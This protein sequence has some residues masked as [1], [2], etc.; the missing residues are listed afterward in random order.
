MRFKQFGKYLVDN[1]YADGYDVYSKDSNWLVSKK[2]VN[3]INETTLDEILSNHKKISPVKFNIGRLYFLSLH[4]KFS[5]NEI[6][7]WLLHNKMY[8]EYNEL[9][10]MKLEE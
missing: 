5:F 8:E 10:L 6:M 4:S 1:S 2:L 9:L 3:L 7:K